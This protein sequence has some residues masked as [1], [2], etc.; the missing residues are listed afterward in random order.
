MGGR[1][2]ARD[3]TWA[4]CQ[5]CRACGPGLRS[6]HIDNSAKATANAVLSIMENGERSHAN[7]IHRHAR[8]HP[9]MRHAGIGERAVQGGVGALA[10][11]ARHLLI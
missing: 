5:D 10:K 9:V 6:Q 8:A 11:R 3:T 7:A 1:V 2:V 4:Q